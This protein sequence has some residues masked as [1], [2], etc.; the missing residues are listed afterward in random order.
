[1]SEAASPYRP[2]MTQA[3][4]T[5]THPVTAVGEF[6]DTREVQV[7]GEF[8]LTLYVDGREIVTL[9]T[10]DAHPEALV[11]GYLHTQRFIAALE[12]IRSV[13]R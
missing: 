4:L 10:L 5:P 11:L 6:G 1:M 8:P 12:E 2:R 13:H 3:G 7:A 9:M